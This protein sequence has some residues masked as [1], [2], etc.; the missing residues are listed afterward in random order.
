[1][2]LKE[3]NGDVENYLQRIGDQSSRMMEDISDI[4][5]SINPHNDSLK[6]VI[7]RMREFSTEILESKSISYHFSEKVSEGLTLNAD[8]R[9]NLFLIFKESV[10]NA[11]KYSKATHLEINLHQDDHT[12]VM[13]VK[14]NGHGFD[15]TTIKSG[16]GLRNMR[17]RAKEINGSVT[18]NSAAETGTAIELRLPLA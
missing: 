15:E 16:N 7:I 4:V 17:E 3:K 10:N 13:Q 9:K 1:V 18:L 2:A 8:K 14:D 6:Q 11:A 12:L 5:W